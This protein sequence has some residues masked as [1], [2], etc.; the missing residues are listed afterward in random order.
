M[1]VS[2][3]VPYGSFA[4]RAENNFA[5]A[6]AGFYRGRRS[7]AD[8]RGKFSFADIDVRGESKH[9]E[10]IFVESLKE[11]NRVTGTR[12]R[13]NYL[14][15]A[16]DIRLGRLSRLRARA[17]LSVCPRNIFRPALRAPA[18]VIKI[19]LQSP[20]RNESSFADIIK[21][22]MNVKRG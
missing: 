13:S 2:A 5:I 22:L 1:L 6:K 15:E 17:P 8:I 14:G 16:K 10:R 4:L 19:L 20:P 3:R 11:R 9:G 7:R 12:K 18:R 21:C